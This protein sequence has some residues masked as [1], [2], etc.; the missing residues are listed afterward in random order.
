[1]NVPVTVGLLYS[2]G[3]ALRA[4]GAPHRMN[5]P[6]WGGV[7][8]CFG[9]ALRAC[10]A[11]PRAPAC[12]ERSANRVLTPG[13]AEAFGT[14]AFGLRLRPIRSREKLGHA[15]RE[16]HSV[17]AGRAMGSCSTAAET[18]RRSAEG[19]GVAGCQDSVGAPLPAGWGPGQS[20]AGAQRRVKQQSTSQHL[21]T[22]ILC[23]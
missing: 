2:F 1:M 3:V 10:G 23:R 6:I 21:G 14:P 18:K 16:R 9:A 19:L 7:V 17:I 12:W 11:L 13:H 4:C 22:F 15:V 5:V 8:Y 20:P